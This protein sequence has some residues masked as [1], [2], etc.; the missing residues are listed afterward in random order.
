MSSHIVDLWFPT[1]GRTLPSDHGYPVYGALCNECP[2]LHGSSWWGL[3]TVSGTLRG[4]GSL[5]LP[6]R[7]SLGL[8]LPADRIG[9][10][11][12]LAGRKI[13]VDGHSI[14]LAPPRV[15]PLQ[16]AAAVS[17]R[18][19]TIKGFM[20][21]EPFE[22]AVERQLEELEI[23]GSI[24]VGPRKVVQVREHTIVGFSVRIFDITPEQSLRLQREGIGGRRRFGCGLFNPSEHP[25]TPES[26]NNVTRETAS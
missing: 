7:S 8:R 26:P 5:V 14:R 20:E 4:D 13:N 21:P 12:T 3:H 11:L 23:E 2:E 9:T 22:S 6:D 10:V 1:L 24:Q 17:A 18:I 19:V 15:E 16:P 25:L